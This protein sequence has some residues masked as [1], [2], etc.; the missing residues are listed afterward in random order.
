MKNELLRPYFLLILLIGVGLLAAH[1]F[2]PF[3]APLMLAVVFA[4]ILQG[5]HGKVQKM[6][7]GWPSIG[8]LVTVLVSAVFILVPLCIIGFFV[9]REAGTLYTSL[10]E[11]G[12]PS[13]ISQMVVHV[14]AAFGE[15]I[16]GVR[17]YSQNISANIDLYLKQ[18][19]QWFIQHAG[20]VFTGI[21]SLLISFFIFLV[22]LYYLLRDGKRARAM[23]I[24]LSPLND[25]EDEKVFTQL[26]HAINSIIKGSLTIA[27]IQGVLTAIGFTIFGIPNSILWG[28]VASLAALIPGIGTSLV[29]IPGVLFLFFTGAVPQSIGLL[30][31]GVVAVGLIDNFLGPKLMGR[32][33]ELHPFLILLAVLGG[34]MVFGAIGIF[35]GPLSLCLLFALLSI[36]SSIVKG[37]A[38]N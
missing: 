13:L 21:S 19:L 37:S 10:N 15:S 35:L 18:A 30:A 31:W 17:E 33:T 14:D 28:L 5:L 2:E 6:F 4:V 23:L 34:I 11:N 20:V 29:L 16:P 24:E 8:A 32:G 25:K 7:K 36:Y 3:F 9:V 38:A 12:A 26:E 1:I 22:A 27:L